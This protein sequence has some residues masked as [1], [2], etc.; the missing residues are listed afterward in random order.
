MLDEER[1]FGKMADALEGGNGISGICWHPAQFRTAC[2]RFSV[3]FAVGRTL[4]APGGRQSL[5]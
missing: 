1:R 4:K 5:A 3:T 2:S